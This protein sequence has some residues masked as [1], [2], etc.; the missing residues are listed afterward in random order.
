MIS[1]RSAL[2]MKISSYNIKKIP[3]LSS[4][5]EILRLVFFIVEI[6]THG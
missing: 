1:N 2:E 5:K 4:Y 6:D 3:L